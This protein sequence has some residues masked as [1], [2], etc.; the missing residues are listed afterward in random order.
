M[1]HQS[2]NS[3]IFIIAIAVMAIVLGLIVQSQQNR[4]K[5]LPELNK[6]IVL[7]TPKSITAEGLTDHLGQAFGIEQLSGKWSVLFFGF[8]NC[9]DICPTTMQTLKLVKSQLES[10]GVWNNYQVV[11]VSVDPQRDTTERLASYVPHFDSEFIG[12]SGS[13]AD[14]EIFAMQLGILF[15]KR[16][17]AS[18]IGYDVDH[19]A[20]MVL[21]NP[22]GQYAGVI[23]APHQADT[24]SE[25]LIELAN[26]SGLISN[27]SK[28]S[29]KTPTSIAQSTPNS[30]V[31]DAE[32]SIQKAWIRP[33]PPGVKSMAAY[34]TLRNNSDADIAIVTASSPAF[35]MAMIHDTEIENGVASMT[36][37][38]SLVIPAHGAKEL[39]PMATHMMLISP[40]KEL[41][42]GDEVKITLVDE[43]GLLYEFQVTVQPAPSE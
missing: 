14:T 20:S 39:A 34:F 3:T 5:E 2:G 28:P 7:P 42:L 38:D 35:K 13:V 32:L 36:H 21:I 11:M 17:S 29:D 27:S 15:V 12:I 10:A 16:D 22:Q 37:L 26:F 9:P 1:K 31:A 33:A 30:R 25:D 43:S 40:V 41:A 8:T 18:G 23:T 4:P 19:S 6:T 24:I